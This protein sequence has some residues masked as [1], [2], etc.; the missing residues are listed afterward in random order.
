M[1]L[2]TDTKHICSVHFLHVKNGYGWLQ[3]HLFDEL[4][5]IIPYHTS[6]ET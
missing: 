3:S 2:A 5:Q 6:T 4:Q 1:E